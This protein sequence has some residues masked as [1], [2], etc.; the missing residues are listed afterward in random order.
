MATDIAE[1][2]GGAVALNLLFGIPL[3]WGGVITGT[4]SIVLL[5]CSRGGVR[6]RS[7]SS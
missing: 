4:V 3:L 7:S 5:V 1:V 2:I 6:A